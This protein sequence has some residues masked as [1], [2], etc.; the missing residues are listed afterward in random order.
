MRQGSDD[1]SLYRNSM[2]IDLVVKGLT[3]GNC[4]FGILVSGHGLAVIPEVKLVEKV[5]TC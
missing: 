5:K 3:E 2:S 4:I 1:L